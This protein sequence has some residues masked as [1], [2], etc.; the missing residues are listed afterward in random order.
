MKRFPLLLPVLIFLFG[1]TKNSSTPPTPPQQQA[2]TVSA[3]SPS[4]GSAG[5]AVTI[6]GTNFSSTVSDN[7][8]KFNGTAATVNSASSTSLT[9][10]APTG[11][12]T[13]N[14]TVT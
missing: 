4:S 2:P 12:T 13:G 9:V 10:E 6:T 5:T 1:C 8:V 3:I 7:T 11:G 14:V